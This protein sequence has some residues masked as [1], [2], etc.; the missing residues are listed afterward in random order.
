MSSLDPNEDGGGGGF[1]Y[2]D[3]LDAARDGGGMPREFSEDPEDA[4]DAERPND[5]PAALGLRLLL[6]RWV[7]TSFA[8]KPC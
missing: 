5:D 4:E 8:V 6:V 3:A 2:A 1:L 7:C